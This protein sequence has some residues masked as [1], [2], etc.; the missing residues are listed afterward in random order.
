MST[1]DH[2][3]GAQNASR[4]NVSK[5]DGTSPTTSATDC[6]SSVRSFDAIA[7]TTTTSALTMARTTSVGR[8]DLG[9]S[10]A[11]ANNWSPSVFLASGRMA[12]PGLA[13]GGC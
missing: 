2:A 5:N 1:S 6:S 8:R 7:A 10:C 9:S 3:T 12:D 11:D 13:M 4:H